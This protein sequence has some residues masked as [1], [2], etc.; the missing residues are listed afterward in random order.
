MTITDV[1]SS[2]LGPAIAPLEKRIQT[3]LTHRTME[4]VSTMIHPDKQ[5][6]RRSFLKGAAKAGAASFA[7]SHTSIKVENCPAYST[8]EH[9]VSEAGE[10]MEISANTTTVSEARPWRREQP[11]QSVANKLAEERLDLEDEIRTENTFEAIIGESPALK[12]VLKQVEIVT[13]HRFHSSAFGR[14]WDRQGTDCAGHS[15]SEFRPQT[16]F[17]ERKLRRHPHGPSRK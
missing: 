5:L 14:D 16:D 2:Q 8:S 10:S 1:R 3:Q 9:R 4:G 15:Q 17:G 12:C 7:I 11:E 13:S 6:S